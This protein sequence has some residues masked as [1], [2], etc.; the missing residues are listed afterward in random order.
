MR[1]WGI[2][3]A[4]LFFAC[5]T[6]RNL[7]AFFSFEGS[8]QGWE[9]HGADLQGPAGEDAWSIT[10]DPT[11]P[12]DGASSVRFFLDDANGAG[13]I[14]LERTF[15]LPSSRRRTL[16]LDFATAGSSDALLPDRLIVG[17]FP[18]AP[19]SEDAIQSAL[20]PA[21]IASF[22]WTSHAYDFEVDGSAVVVI[23][24]VAGGTTGRVIYH[25]DAMTVLFTDL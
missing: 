2:L 16:H 20:Q 11:V 1:S 21:G 24:G 13:K 10:T 23:V 18:A 3:L 17:A 15:T 8:L 6:P 25:L 14:W 22:Q 19:R 5:G 7:S 9:P 4:G 12:F